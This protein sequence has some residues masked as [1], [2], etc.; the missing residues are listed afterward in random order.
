MEAHHFGAHSAVIRT[1]GH[2]RPRPDWCRQHGRAIAMH[3]TLKRIDACDELAGASE[4]HRLGPVRLELVERRMLGNQSSNR[5]LSERRELP[6]IALAPGTP[7]I[8]R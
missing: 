5:D 6:L 3:H 8:W 2:R 7:V 1:G 4:R